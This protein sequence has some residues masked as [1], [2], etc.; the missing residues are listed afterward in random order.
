MFHRY[1]IILFFLF[2]GSL[3]AQ[4]KMKKINKNMDFVKKLALSSKKNPIVS[5]HLTFNTIIRKEKV[6]PMRKKLTWYEKNKINL[7]NGGIFLGSL[8]GF[9]GFFNFIDG[10]YEIQEEINKI[11]NLMIPF[12]YEGPVDFCYDIK[13]DKDYSNRIKQNNYRKAEILL[14]QFIGCNKENTAIIGD[15]QKDMQKD[16]KNF[17]YNGPLLKA[18]GQYYKSLEQFAEQMKEEVIKYLK[19]KTGLTE[20]NLLKKEFYYLA[21]FE[22]EKNTAGAKIID[23]VQKT[24]LQEMLTIKKDDKNQTME[25]NNANLFFLLLGNYLMKQEDIFGSQLLDI[26]IKGFEKYNSSDKYYQETLTENYSNIGFWT[27]SAKT[28]KKLFKSFFYFKPLAF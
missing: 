15:I 3:M 2:N 23:K 5:N 11:N 26:I 8:W 21:M 1:Y 24:S 6:K 12:H 14:T 19:K 18:E 25:I 9:N 13:K 16:K 28:T 7:R 10:S 22:K 20:E 27:K 4:S 17:K